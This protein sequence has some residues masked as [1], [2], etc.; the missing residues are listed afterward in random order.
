MTNSSVLILQ[1]FQEF[2]R[3]SSIYF[4]NRENLFELKNFLTNQKYSKTWEDSWM[5]WFNKNNMN[6]RYFESV[7]KVNNN[8]SLQTFLKIFDNSYQKND[9]QNP[10]GE[11]GDY[12]K[13]TEKVWNIHNKT[14][15]LEYFIVYKKNKPVAVSTLTKGSSENNFHRF[16]LM[17]AEYSYCDRAKY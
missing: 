2:E 1:K 13:T 15:R 12:L 17:R 14:N 10:Y 3:N 16:C 5:F 6:K 8:S 4:E 7:K 11:L 9:P